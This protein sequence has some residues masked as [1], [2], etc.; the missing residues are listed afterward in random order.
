ME[1]PAPA[2]LLEALEATWP[3]AETRACDGWTIRRG[4]G[5]GKR[6][7][8]ASGFGA[9]ETAERA[10]AAWDQAPL[11]RSGPDQT[12]LEDLL[13]RTGY[14][15]AD[16]T[17]FCVAPAAALDDGADETAKLVRVSTP[18]AVMERLWEAGGVG[19]ARRR[20]M[21]RAADPKI[22]L[23]ARAGQRPAGVAFVAVDREIAFLH[24]MEVAPDYRRQGA[25]ARLA[26]GAARFAAEHGARWLALAVTEANAAA[27]A[28]Y[29]S[30]GMVE[31]GGYHY[32][33]GPTR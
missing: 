22:W 17:V 4:E 18:L 32:R 1:R 30:L 16:P 28:L 20:V 12:K 8:A 10:M 2:R 21:A 7:S 33:T 31:A 5:G 24:A 11:V 23:L 3:P 15:I 19:V 6:V 27:R 14:G 29:R 25:G 9:V 26:R 13:D